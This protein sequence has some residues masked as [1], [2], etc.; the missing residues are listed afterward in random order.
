[1]SWPLLVWKT[2]S[3]IHSWL[4]SSKFQWVPYS[5]RFWSIL[6]ILCQFSVFCW[7][8][9][10]V[11][12]DTIPNFDHFDPDPYIHPPMFGS[13][14]LHDSPPSPAAEFLRN[15]VGQGALG[16]I[17][18]SPSRWIVPS[19]VASERVLPW[20]SHRDNLGVLRNWPFKKKPMDGGRILR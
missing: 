15:E 2:E 6:A 14:R 7:F 11:F 17:T 10:P 19:W 1:M 16:K 18:E 8:Y 3:L 9:P 4:I 5:S 13:P 12:A 20:S